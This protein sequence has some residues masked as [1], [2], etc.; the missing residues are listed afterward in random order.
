MT[1]T[2]RLAIVIC[3]SLLASPLAMRAEWEAV[4]TLTGYAVLPADTLADGPPSGAFISGGRRNST[5][6]FASQP[7]GGFSSLA[8]AR[9]GWWW[10]L[11]DNL[12]G[13]KLS[14]SDILLR[15]YRVRPVWLERPGER[16]RVEVAS[17]IVQLSDPNHRVPFRTVNEASRDR[18]LTGA[19]FDPESLVAMPDGTFWIGDE[20]GPF[21][22]H[23]D[24]TGRLLDAPVEAPGLRSPDHPLLPPADRGRTSE[25]TVGRSRGFEGLSALPG[26]STLLVLLEAGG[27]NDPPASTRILEFNPDNGNWTGRTWILPLTPGAVA[28]TEL[29]CYRAAACLVI[30]R[31]D[32]QAE[33]AMVKLVM[34]IGLPESGGEVEKGFVADL[35]GISDPQNLAGFGSGFRFPFMTPEAVWP[36]DERTLVLV[37][38][39]NFPGEGGRGKGVRDESEFIR[40]R[41]GTPLP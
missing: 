5:P 33:R 1:R 6:R 27:G 39:N 36:L 16:G 22:L 38:D 29:V 14:S 12:F 28:A 30:E 20:F 41:L 3:V 7:V 26:T 35:L 23:V 31:D 10:A 32:A 9:D 17:D 19:D 15:I 25:A 11:A 37:N 34:A 18:L 21:L 40:I 13:T 4:A 8:P 2:S 24:A